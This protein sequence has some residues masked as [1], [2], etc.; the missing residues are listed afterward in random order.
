MMQPYNDRVVWCESA[1]VLP[2]FQTETYSPEIM[3]KGGRV[4][5]KEKKKGKDEIQGTRAASIM[6]FGAEAICTY[7][8][9]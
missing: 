9:P 1:Q 6:W 2:C 3:E 8:S 7:C 5:S 4:K